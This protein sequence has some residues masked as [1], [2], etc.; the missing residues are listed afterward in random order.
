MR[1][2]IRS[3]DRIGYETIEL[4]PLLF[5]PLGILLEEIYYSNQRT[6]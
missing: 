3:R 4:A 1:C 6:E 2:R 5:S